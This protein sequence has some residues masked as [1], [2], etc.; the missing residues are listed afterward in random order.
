LI[1]DRVVWGQIGIYGAWTSEVGCHHHVED[2]I[3]IEPC[4]LPLVHDTVHHLHV[5]FPLL[6]ILTLPP[7]THGRLVWQPHWSVNCAVITRVHR[8]LVQLGVYNRVV[9]LVSV[10]RVNCCFLINIRTN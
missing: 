4:A 8:G 9:V 3:L 7:S 5:C 6:L 2:P 10:V 1:L